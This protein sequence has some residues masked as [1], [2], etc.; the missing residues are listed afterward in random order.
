MDTDDTNNS[1]HLSFYFYNNGNLILIFWLTRRGILQC[2]PWAVKMSFERK[3]RLHVLL[4]R[5]RQAAGMSYIGKRH[6]GRTNGW[7][8][9]YVGSRLNAKVDVLEVTKKSLRALHV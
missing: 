6:L 2:R 3:D 9:L 7:A 5:S 4:P 1:N 8:L